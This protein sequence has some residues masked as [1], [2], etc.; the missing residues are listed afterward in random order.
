MTTTGTGTIAN[1]IAN[2]IVNTIA[3]TG[4]ITNT[5]TLVNNA[6]TQYTN[7]TITCV[8]GGTVPVPLTKFTASTGALRLILP[9][10]ADGNVRA[11]QIAHITEGVIGTAAAVTLVAASPT[12]VVGAAAAV[13]LV[14]ASPTNMVG[15]TGSL[16]VSRPAGC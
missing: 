9:C 5:G 13:T 1:T 14:A 7:E 11:S 4:S 16:Q 8:S 6:L 3:S 12:G 15:T 2:T 10:T